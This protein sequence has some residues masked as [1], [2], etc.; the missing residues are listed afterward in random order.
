MPIAQ[1][2]NAIGIGAYAFIPGVVAGEALDPGVAVAVTPAGVVRCSASSFAG[3]FAGFTLTTVPVGNSVAVLSMRGSSVT[4]VIEGGGSFAVG[5][6][7]FLSNSLGQVTQTSPDG[8]NLTSIQIG[9]ATTATSMV[10]LTDLR[11]F[12]LG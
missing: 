6:P 4:P 2:N 5:Q 3:S 1:S 10:L 8:P 11:V 9:V 7:V 12:L